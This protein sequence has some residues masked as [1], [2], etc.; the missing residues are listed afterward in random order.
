M[1]LRILTLTG[2][3]VALLPLSAPDAFGGE[4]TV[5]ARIDQL[6]NAQLRNEGVPPSPR[7]D[8]TEFPE[9]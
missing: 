9:R 2:V 3:C 4:P 1:K 7:S 8:D 6:I 5:T